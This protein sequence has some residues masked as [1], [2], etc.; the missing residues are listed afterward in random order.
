MTAG[1]RQAPDASIPSR[2]TSNRTGASGADQPGLS[3]PVVERSTLAACFQDAGQREHGVGS[4][5]TTSATP[6]SSRQRRP[7][8]RLAPSEMQE[9]PRGR[10]EV[11]L[12]KIAQL[13][14][15]RRLPD[16]HLP[17][18]GRRDHHRAAG[19]PGPVDRDEGRSS[20]VG[21]SFGRCGPRLREAV[22]ERPAT[23]ENAAAWAFHLCRMGPFGLLPW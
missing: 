12:R 11:E 8:P 22:I 17:P 15:P 16:P 13:T 9:T 19:L 4:S 20:S 6:P 2:T 14:T 18:A 3:A 21:R 1:I 5:T 7:R 23:A 10:P